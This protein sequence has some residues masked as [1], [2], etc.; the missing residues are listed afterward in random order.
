MSR[1]PMDDD[2][3]ELLG[4]YAL[5]ALDA[6][7]RSRVETLLSRSASARAE[8][9]RYDHALA[10]LTDA[11][12]TTPP[13]A[14]SWD[15][16]RVAMHAGREQAVVPPPPLPSAAPADATAVVVPLRPRRRTALF[17]AA[18]AIV[19]AGLGVGVAVERQRSGSGSRAQAAEAAWVAAGSVR[20]EVASADGAVRLRAVVDA[21]GDG[22]LFADGLAA[23]PAG[24]TYQLW[25][26]DGPAPVSLGVLGN[27]P[28]VVSFSTGNQ[29]RALAISAERSPGAASPTLPPVAA[30]T[31]T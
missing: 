29:V 23:L 5:G 16:L 6:D 4:A 25:S 13:P 26:L 15:R 7:E 11:E 27:R 28:G 18:A 22:Y 14:G 10:G 2:T 12:V 21:K 19:V 24:R 9:A 30:G 1:P 3:L 8:L 20:G 17:A 31:L